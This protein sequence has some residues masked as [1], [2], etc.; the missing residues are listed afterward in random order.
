MSMC[1]A[2]APFPGGLAQLGRCAAPYAAFPPL[3]TQGRCR[4]AGAPAL[5]AR[6]AAL[7]GGSGSADWAFL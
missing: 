5:A 4:W 7:P 3:S 1:G 2:T 6:A